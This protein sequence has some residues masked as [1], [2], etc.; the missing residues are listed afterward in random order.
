MRS[1]A[2]TIESD[3]RCDVKN[4]GSTGETIG[5]NWSSESKWRRGQ[6]TTDPDVGTCVKCDFTD[7][8]DDRITHWLWSDV[9]THESSWRLLKYECWMLII[10]AM[11][12]ITYAGFLA[13]NISCQSC[14]RVDTGTWL[15]LIPRGV[16]THIST[17]RVH[18]STRLVTWKSRTL[19]EKLLVEKTLHR[20]HEHVHAEPKC[21]CCTWE[22]FRYALMMVRRP[23]F[24]IATWFKSNTDASSCEDWM[25]LNIA[26]LMRLLNCWI[27]KIKSRLF[28]SL[29]GYGTNAFS[30]NRNA[31]D[32]LECRTTLSA[33][34]R[35]SIE[36]S[37]VMFRRYDWE[38]SSEA[39]VGRLEKMW[40]AEF[41]HVCPLVW[42]R[43]CFSMETVET[44]LHVAVCVWTLSMFEHMCDQLN[45]I[46]RVWLVTRDCSLQF[47]LQR[48]DC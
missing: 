7:V 14:R 10:I 27:E 11:Q 30:L 19:V 2:R 22:M 20:L 35:M 21:C 25:S 4:D 37:R 24:V 6:K 28:S 3:S 47:I 13:E 43:P 17:P 5:V 31:V 40:I 38:R 15:F 48:I 23:M 41:C 46:V 45:R 18:N 42:I 34:N 12:I 29:R 26:L 33:R 36:G 39:I 8:C 1:C 32:E 44:V 9:T 16:S